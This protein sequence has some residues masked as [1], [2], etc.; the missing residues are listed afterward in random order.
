MTRGK[1]VIAEKRSKALNDSDNSH[2]E[3]TLVINEEPN[4]HKLKEGIRIKDSQLGDI[5]KDR[6]IEL[7]K[8]IWI[9][10]KLKY[11]ETHKTQNSNIKSVE[12][13]MRY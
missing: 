12:I 6:L 13:I 8:R 10:E 2:E 9:Y 4:Y 3:F 11:N 7:D 5:K 1:L